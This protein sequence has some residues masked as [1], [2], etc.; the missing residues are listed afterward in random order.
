[1]EEKRFKEWIILKEKIHNIARIRTIREGEVWWAALGENVGVEINGKNDGFTRPILV[2][3]K[4][5]RF[6]FLG[7]PLTTQ[8]H[9]GTWYSSFEFKNKKQFAALSQIR[10]L[11]VSRL[12][13]R[14]GML[15]HS[16]FDVVKAGFKRLYLG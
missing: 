16:D 1:M 11:S 15:T 13:K 14:M 12:N 7:V 9:Y 4:L 3:K 10:I 8:E 5:S 2:F 6:S